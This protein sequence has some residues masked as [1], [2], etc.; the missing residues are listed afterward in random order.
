M[1]LAQRIR[2]IIMLNNLCDIINVNREQMRKKDGALRH[3]MIY[4]FL[5]RF[6]IT[7]CWHEADKRVNAANGEPN[8]RWF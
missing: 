1:L 6:P 2:K 8:L 5:M 4:S 3:T 7:D